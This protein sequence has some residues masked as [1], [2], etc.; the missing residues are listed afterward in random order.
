MKTH[1][2]ISKQLKRLDITADDLGKYADLFFGKQEEQIGNEEEKTMHGDE[3]VAMLMQLRP[4][5]DINL[6][7]F[8]MFR[9]KVLAR[10]VRI[11]KYLDVLE[12]FV[13]ELG[14]FDDSDGETRAAFQA[15]ATESRA[16][17]KR[18]SRKSSRNRRSTR[19][20]VSG[21][22]TQLA[23]G[24]A[25]RRK[26]RR[27]PSTLIRSAAM[28]ASLAPSTV[29]V[30]HHSK[31]GGAIAAQ[32][33]ET[34]TTL[35]D[36]PLDSKI[37]ELMEKRRMKYLLIQEELEMQQAMVTE[38]YAIPYDADDYVWAVTTDPVDTTLSNGEAV[39]PSSSE[40][41]SAHPDSAFP[42]IHRAWL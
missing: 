17:H 39:T 29:S 31:G 25:R 8:K 11:G 14:G 10:N 28:Q 7:D 41:G 5:K 30:W 6:C 33:V 4:G 16:N 35:L 15:K 40:S 37:Q 36:G 22:R 9:N 24:P 12:W 26:A 2:V 32:S 19:I 18:G 34:G 20:S 23:T 27:S 38:T 42:Q 1:P 21:S 3:C 13:E